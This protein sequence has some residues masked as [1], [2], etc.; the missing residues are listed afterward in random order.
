MFFVACVTVT[1]T[2]HA[3]AFEHLLSHARLSPIRRR[4]GLQ[5]GRMV[6]GVAFLPTQSEAGLMIRQDG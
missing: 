4:E 1:A 2:L 5:T 3:T 6:G